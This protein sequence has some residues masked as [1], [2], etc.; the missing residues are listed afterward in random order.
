MKITN[1]IQGENGHFLLLTNIKCPAA[2]DFAYYPHL[3][4][5]V[6][7]TGEF[8]KISHEDEYNALYLKHKHQAVHFKGDV[9]F[10]A[11]FVYHDFD[12]FIEIKDTNGRLLHEECLGEDDDWG[13]FTDIMEYR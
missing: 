11:E 6:N 8:Q 10:V 9:T 4:V 7:E 12:N 3:A 5:W 13:V 2:L 1:S